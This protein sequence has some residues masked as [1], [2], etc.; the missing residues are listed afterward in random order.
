MPRPR[1]L[2]DLS[3]MVF[4]APEIQKAFAH[5]GKEFEGKSVGEIFEQG[6]I[7]REKFIRDMGE[8]LKDA[9][10]EKICLLVVHGHSWIS[11]YMLVYDTSWDSAQSNAW[12][13]KEIEGVQQRFQYLSKL[14]ASD[15]EADRQLILA[16]LR[17]VVETPGALVPTHHPLVQ[18]VKR[19][20]RDTGDEDNPDPWIYEELKLPDKNTAAR[21]LA[22]LRGMYPNEKLDVNV[23]A[24]VVTTDASMAFLTEKAKSPVFLDAA[25][26]ALSLASANAGQT[27]EQAIERLKESWPKRVDT[28]LTASGHIRQISKGMM[29]RKSERSGSLGRLGETWRR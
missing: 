7:A 27:L 1:K 6:W 9:N 26:S 19:K 29:D 10:H 12:R 4:S 13:V 17:S 3:L 28:S 24:A 22:K 8:P 5:A 20:R 21:E 11:A 15:L 18:E 16:Y 14:M 2:P 25:Q 23:R